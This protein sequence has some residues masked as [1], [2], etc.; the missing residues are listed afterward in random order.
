MNQR[1]T[2]QVNL[3]VEAGQD[4]PLL[5]KRMFGRSFPLAVLDE[6][7]TQRPQLGFGLMCGGLNE[8]SSSGDFLQ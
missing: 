1:L 2:C 6:A 4:L 8:R 3:G 7:V 5:A